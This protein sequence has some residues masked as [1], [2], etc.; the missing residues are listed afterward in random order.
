MLIYIAGPYTKGD[1][2]GNVRRAC[3]AGAQILKKGHTPFI[4]HLSHFWHLISP[5]SWETWLKIDFT[6]LD[7]CD[8]LLRLDGESKGAEAEEIAASGLG[9][10]IYHSLDEVPNERTVRSAIDKE[11]MK[12]LLKWVI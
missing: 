7:R 4:P 12:C 11:E 1:T 10:F 9:K 8:A 6:L 3:L 2:A 5:K